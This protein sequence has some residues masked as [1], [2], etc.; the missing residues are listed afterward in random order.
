MKF[1]LLP[2]VKDWLKALGIALVVCWLVVNILGKTSFVRESGMYPNLYAGDFVWVNKWSCGFVFPKYPLSL[3][4]TNIEAKFLKIPYHRF[5]NIDTSLRGEI[6]A[7]TDPLNQN[8]IR[9]GRL[10]AFSGERLEL[11]NGHLRL[12]NEDYTLKQAI[13]QQYQVKIRSDFRGVIANYNIQDPLPVSNR[14]DWLFN[15]YNEQLLAFQADPRIQH[16]RLNAKKKGERDLDIFPYNYNLRYN[17]DHWG[18]V[19]IP[20]KNDS[21]ISNTTW[22]AILA[23]TLAIDMDSLSRLYQNHD[24]DSLYMASKIKDYNYYI[25]LSD[26]RAVGVDS[27]R[28]GLLREDY[29]L[30]TVP[31]VFF[32]LNNQL[33]FKAKMKRIFTAL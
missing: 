23:Q 11:E 13:C 10:I 20:Q 24:A 5:G 15:L 3:P 33:G 30:G 26:N 14:N 9:Y 17:Q 18:P 6:I 7:Y 1:T 27:R 22:D 28:L 8:T 31:F 2:K 12:N 32:S 21:L 4:G 25:V 16:V 19:Y 29:I